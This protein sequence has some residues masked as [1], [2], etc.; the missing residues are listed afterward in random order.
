MSCSWPL[1]NSKLKKSLLCARLLDESDGRKTILSPRSIAL[2]R[3]QSDAGV[4]LKHGP[5]IS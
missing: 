1:E 5:K 2:R 3:L 4:S